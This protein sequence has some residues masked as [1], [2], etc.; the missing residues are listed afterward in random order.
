MY[1]QSFHPPTSLRDFYRYIRIDF[2]SHYSNEYYCP[3]S[4]LRVYGLTHLEQW[5][6]DIW[7]AESR[8]K[9]DELEEVKAI[10]SPVGVAGTAEFAQTPAAD[11]SGN[12]ETAVAQSS[13]VDPEHDTPANA[14]KEEVVDFK[15]ALENVGISSTPNMTTDERVDHQVPSSSLN[16]KRLATTTSAPSEVSESSATVPSIDSSTAARHN[17]SPTHETSRPATTDYSSDTVLPASPTFDTLSVSQLF[18]TS[19]DQHLPSSYDN[20]TITVIHSRVSSGSSSSATTLTTS[21]P[22]PQPPAPSATGG[23]SIYRTIMNRLTALEANHTLYARYVEEQ[24]V[25]VRDMLKRLGE[26]VGRLEGIVSFRFML[27]H[28]YS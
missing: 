8:A 11:A 20:T 13:G 7:E 18:N 23:E 25:G 14:T 27:R 21:I 6:W 12:S 10:S 22:L 24:T 4:L 2:R 5:K 26:E 15:N 28:N 1:S 16:G 19:W 3:V 9:Q 17:D